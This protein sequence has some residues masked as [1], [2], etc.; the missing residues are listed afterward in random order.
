LFPMGPLHRTLELA[1]TGGAANGQGDGVDQFLDTQ[2][3]DP[4]DT[5]MQAEAN[6]SNDLVEGTGSLG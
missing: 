5:F 2:A 4:L 1:G 3:R 6:A